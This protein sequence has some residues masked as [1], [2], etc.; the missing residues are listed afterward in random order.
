MPII[1]HMEPTRPPMSWEAFCRET[2]ERSIAVDGF[3]D[4]PPSFDLASLHFNFDHHRG[5]TRIAML[6]SA[7]QVREAIHDGLLEL[8]ES[9]ARDTHVFMNDN[10][11]DVALSKFALDHPWIVKPKLGSAVNRLFWLVG[12]MDKRSGLIDL[13]GEIDIIGKAAWMFEAYWEYRLTGAI[14]RK[15]ASEHLRVLA[16]VEGRIGDF[17]AGRGESAPIQDAYETLYRGSGYE[18]VREYGPHCRMKMARRGLRAF[19]SARQTPEDRW[20]YTLC[21]YSPFIY[22]FPVPEIAEALN[23]DEDPDVLFGGG[24]TVYG[25]ARGRGSTR[26]PREIAR[27]IDAYLADHH[28]SPP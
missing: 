16:D 22:W 6:C 19:V 14:D 13:P 8:L 4:G 25:N 7:E 10:D 3:V 26:D 5:P 28:L 11:P 27:A 18:I 24:D 2:P 9:D 1:Y 12:M 23:Q 20:V 21:R 15:V 17:V